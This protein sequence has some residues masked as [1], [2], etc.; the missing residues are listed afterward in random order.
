[1]ESI[2]SV[3]VYPVT[4]GEVAQDTQEV[5]RKCQLH[6]RSEKTISKT[7]EN[8]FSTICTT[9]PSIKPYRVEINARGCTGGCTQK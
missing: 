2:Y 3:A 8:P 9:P 5:A 4:A 7:V 6:S 1:M